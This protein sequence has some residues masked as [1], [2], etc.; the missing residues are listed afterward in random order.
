MTTRFQRACITSLRYNFIDV[1]VLVPKICSALK[2]CD[3]AAAD[4]PWGSV[5]GNRPVMIAPRDDIGCDKHAIL[6]NGSAPALYYLRDSPDTGPGPTR[7]RPSMPP[8]RTD[9]A[10]KACTTCRRQ[11]TRCY[12][13]DTG[14]AACL[15][16]Q[17]LKQSCSLEL[18]NEVRIP[19]DGS[20]LGREAVQ[21]S[22]VNQRYPLPSEL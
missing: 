17:T 16:C 2:L 14:L 3:H 11:K 1:L 19:G 21:D 18:Q 20:H 6:S 5:W 10:S 9:R 12:Q 22:A 4:M 15:R 8:L 13:S 7:P